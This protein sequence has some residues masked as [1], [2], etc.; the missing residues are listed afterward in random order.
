MTKWVSKTS[1]L[2]LYVS[3]G[4]GPQH[5]SVVGVEPTQG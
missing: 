5:L 4:T 3:G 2:G 1:D